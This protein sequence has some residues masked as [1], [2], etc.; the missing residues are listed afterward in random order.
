MVAPPK[1]EIKRKLGTVPDAW[2]GLQS[3]FIDPEIMQQAAFAMRAFQ[4]APIGSGNGEPGKSACLQPSATMRLAHMPVRRLL[5]DV[6]LGS[7]LVLFTPHSVVAAAITGRSRRLRHLPVLQRPDRRGPRH[8]YR[9]RCDPGGRLP[10][11]ACDAG[12][13]AEVLRVGFK[14]MLRDFMILRCVW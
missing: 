8:H 9:P 3:G 5:S 6:H 13:P 11:N 1:D 4:T 10:G 7:H 14:I 12:R 2:T